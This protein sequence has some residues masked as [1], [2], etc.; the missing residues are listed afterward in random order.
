MERKS[1]YVLIGAAM[2]VFIAAVAGF[3]VWKLRAGDRT[4]YA[5]YD[6]LFSGDVQGLTNDS[7]VFYRGLRV[8]RVHSIQLTSRV[9]TRRATGR[10]RLTEKIEVTVAV[11]WNIDIRERSYAVFEKPFIA[12][13][14]FIQI[15]GRLDVDQIKPKKRLGEKPYPEIRE[16]A[17]FLQATS[18]SAQELL[19]KASVTVDRLNDLLSPDNI[20]AVSDTLRNLSTATTAIAKQDSAIQLT[21]SELPGA[22]AEFRKSFNTLNGL[23]E[24]L[25]LVALELGPQT[26][27]SQK[28]LAGKDPG[29]LRK[30]LTEA[31][32]AMA[33]I[34]S[35]AG[36]LNKMV[37]E[38]KGPDQEL[39]R[40]R[41]HRV[42]AGAARV[43][44]AH[45]QP[46]HHR[47]QAGA[48]SGELRLQW[49]AGI[50]A[51]MILRWARMR[52]GSRHPCRMPGHQRDRFG[53]GADRP[54]HRFPEN[55]VRSR[56]AVGV[57][58]ARRRGAGGQRQPQYRPHRHRHDA[59]LVRLLCQGG[60]DRPRP[61]DGADADRRFV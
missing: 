19:S 29:E 58:A 24:S 52:G 43:A 36:Q 22:I 53:G 45:R 28:A 12:G 46:E 60:V 9:D 26:A 49:Q 1:P 25:N 11:D 14:P 17:S 38:N 33:S 54:L 7:P 27:E 21:L 31:R 34:D 20:G 15:V 18:T 55:N 48:R 40:N 37:V 59:D 50:H 51:E 30:A 44:A 32:K 2:I 42:L 4:A 56:S 3:V 8:G 16:G 47:H 41:P 23:A 39:H 35:A 10:E 57:L 61:P 6:I 13:A 5:Y